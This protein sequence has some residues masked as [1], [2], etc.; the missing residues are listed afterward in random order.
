MVVDWISVYSQKEEW[1][2]RLIWLQKL[3]GEEKPRQRKTTEFQG[4][5]DYT[6]YCSYNWILRS[7]FS[8]GV[9]LDF[10][11]QFFELIFIRFVPVELVD[12]YFSGRKVGERKKFGRSRLSGGSEETTSQS[13]RCHHLGLD[14][15]VVGGKN[16]APEG[17]LSPLEVQLWQVVDEEMNLVFLFVLFW[18]LDDALARWLFLIFFFLF[19]ELV[20]VSL[21]FEVFVTAITIVITCIRWF[22]GWPWWSGPFRFWWAWSKT[23][24]A[25]TG[26]CSWKFA[27]SLPSSGSCLQGK[28]RRYWKGHWAWSLA[29]GKCCSWSRSTCSFSSAFSSSWSRSGSWWSCRSYCSAARLFSSTYSPIIGGPQ[30]G[31]SPPPLSRGPCWFLGSSGCTSYINKLSPL[32]ALFARTMLQCVHVL[33]LF[34]DIR[35]SVSPVL[36]H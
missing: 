21:Q 33:H 1:L 26:K 3:W 31:L 14:D 20:L 6:Y 22:F 23:V 17:T 15:V 5:N 12:D 18:F 30:R 32:S 8:A 13:R 28:L 27:W 7:A 10:P 4:E 2:S 11:L 19:P 35:P 9:R 24:R 29:P 25:W 36:F 16:V 34:A